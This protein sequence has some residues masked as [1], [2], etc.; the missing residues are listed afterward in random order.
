[1]NRAMKVRIM[2]KPMNA[3]RRLYED[4]RGLESIEYA[5]MTALIVGA[6]ALV[7]ALLSVAIAGS[8][9]DIAVIIGP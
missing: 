6:L 3:V 7:V 8:F 9:T 1:M 4:D 2:K 5:V